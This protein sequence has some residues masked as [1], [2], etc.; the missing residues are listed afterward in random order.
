MLCCASEFA[1]FQWAWPGNHQPLHSLMMLLHGIGCRPN[2][3]NLK[4]SCT[5]VDQVLALC[6]PQGGITASDDD[7]LM[8]RPLTEGGSEAWNLVRRL[9]CKLWASLG[10]DPNVLPPREDVRRNVQQQIAAFNSSGGVLHLQTPLPE[11]QMGSYGGQALAN[12][13]G[14]ESAPGTVLPDSMT[15]FTIS[16]DHL[17]ATPFGFTSSGFT[18]N[19][20]WNDWDPLFL[21]GEDQR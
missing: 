21:E 16:Q 11:G 3:P 4:S 12:T 18:P 17:G 14:L 7:E 2:D 10:F 1:R 19:I 15:A 8:A 9:R 20:N 6:G 5:I 13:T